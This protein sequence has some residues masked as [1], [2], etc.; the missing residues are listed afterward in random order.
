MAKV[1]A[2][3]LLDRSDRDRAVSARSQNANAATFSEPRFDALNHGRDRCADVVFAA[4]LVV[5]SEG[6]I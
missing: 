5:V 1:L 3:P 2:T 4:K 6:A